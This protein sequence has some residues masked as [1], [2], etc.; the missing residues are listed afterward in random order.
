MGVTMAIEIN[1]FS[2]IC[3]LITTLLLVLKLTKRSSKSNVPPSP[4]KL[5]L[6][7]N[8]HQLGS[9]PHRSFQ[10]LSRKYG[11]LMLLHLGQ[12]PTLVVQ[13]SEMA[14]EMTKAHDV[15]F[16]TRPQTTA[17]KIFFYQGKDVSFTRYG[18]EW[19]QKRKICVLQLLSP[20]RV[21]SFQFIREEEVAEL[22]HNIRQKCG[23]GG[24]VIN[25]TQMTI[26]ATNNIVSRCVL[27]RKYDAPS[28]SGSFGD[29]A[30]KVLSQFSDFS[31]GDFF[32][33]LGWIDFLTGLI[34]K[35][36]G[37]L[38][39]LDAVFDDVIAQHK[40][41]SNIIEDEERKDFVDI[42]LEIQKNGMLDFELTNDHIKGVLMDLFLGGSDTS[43]A[44]IEWAMA[45]LM[46]SPT[47]M[48]KVQD[49][50]R[51]VVGHKS[52]VEEADVKQ[53]KYLGFVVKEALRLHP[54]NLIIPREARS[55]VKLGGYDIPSKATVFINV[56]A[57]QRDP[58]VWERAE[59][60]IPERFENSE[61]DFKGQDF[62]FIP[63]GSG[64]K[65]CPGM[66]FGVTMVEY[67]LA[68]V[69]YW[70]DWKLP[71]TAQ[72]VDMNEGYGLTVTKK[73]PLLLQPSIFSFS[74]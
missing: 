59:E 14:R 51:R 33:S 62:E 48:R 56:W 10:T 57:I 26:E 18:E 39:E 20:K 6:I 74:P 21:Q 16:A 63:F 46:R 28:G 50:V 4:P 11:P 69:L 36:K 41:K 40:K 47:E 43:S 15:V 24:S 35:L 72:D 53:M 66:T 5:P 32:P 19:R 25:L 60:F 45:E 22:V 17:A 58:Q 27:G 52:K 55:S 8:L 65:G 7:G 37:T 34:S 64:R 61:I 9:L 49:E 68:N 30:R 38:G 13:S 67:V 2:A 70:F 31:V 42:L 71:P 1:A 12:T 3:F 29:V 73:E 54:P 44:T 23:G